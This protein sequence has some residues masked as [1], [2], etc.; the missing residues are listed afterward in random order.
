MYLRVGYFFIMV[1]VI[2]LFIFVASYQTDD[3]DPNYGLL[4]GGLLMIF[5]GIVMVIRNRRPSEK[6]ERFRMIRKMRSRKK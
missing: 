3:H 4:L 6:A 2:V 1:S 5:V